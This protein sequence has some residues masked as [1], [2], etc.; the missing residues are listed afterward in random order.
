[1]QESEHLSKD[2]RVSGFLCP[3]AGSAK[4]RILPLKSESPGLGIQLHHHSLGDLSKLLTSLDP[5]LSNYKMYRIIIILAN[6]K[7]ALVM[8]KPAGS[9]SSLF[10]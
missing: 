3:G 8:C 6:N 2:L 1:M 4:E 9:A 5:S 7:V 10:I